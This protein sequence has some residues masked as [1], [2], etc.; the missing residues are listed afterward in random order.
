MKR[1]FS[2][3]GGILLVSSIYSQ[4][5]ISINPIYFDPIYNGTRDPEIVYN[6]VEKE[7]W[8]YYTSSRP[9]TNIGNFVGTPIG[10]AGSKDLKNWRFIGYC[11][12]NGI[13]GK[14]DAPHTY[15]ALGIIIEGDTAHMFVTFKQDT[16]GSWGGSSKLEHYVSPV[17]NMQK[18]WKYF[19]TVT[20]EPQA[21]DATVIKSENQYLMWYRN[22]IGEPC[23]IYHAKSSDLKNWELLGKTEGDINDINISKIWYQEGP[24]VFKWKNY[25]W[26]ITDPGDGIAVYRSKDADNWKFTGKILLNNEGISPS[27]ASNGKHAS[28]KIIN[29]RAFIFYHTEPY[30]KEDDNTTFQG[31]KFTCYLNMAELKFDGETLTCNRKSPVKLP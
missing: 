22:C 20:N 17:N 26:M 2:I 25:F 13:G 27:E 15:W 19:N 9:V 21:I 4:K 5:D 14:P 23:G 1:I 11:Y 28:V 31:H 24:Y 29:N 10:I 30:A 12:F 18:G 7:Y 6:P 16:I 8:V 3:L